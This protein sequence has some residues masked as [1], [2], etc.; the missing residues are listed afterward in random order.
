VQLHAQTR[1]IFVNVFITFL[2]VFCLGDKSLSQEAPANFQ[3]FIRLEK[4]KYLVGESIRFWSGVKVTDSQSI[5]IAAQRSCSLS[6]TNPDGSTVAQSRDWPRGGNP[7]RSWYG[8]DGF[9]E[10]GVVP[11]PYTLVLECMGIKSKPVQ[12]VVE[13]N[14]VTN[15]VV[16]EFH[17]VGSGSIKI[18]TKVPV[19]LTVQNNS[20]YGIQF[21]ERNLPWEAVSISVRRKEPASRSDFFYP[22][23]KPKKA[24]GIPDT[25]TWDVAPT[26]PSIIL[27]SGERFEQRFALEEAYTFDQAGEYEIEF[28]TILSV[29]IGENN[30]AFS[31]TCPI[32]LPVVAKG[33]FTVSNT[34]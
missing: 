14:E 25:Y 16:A 30:G 17:F 10:L 11:G 27:Q 28:A 20:P 26:I 9:G 24:F 29:L 21:P 6:I 22:L 32:R 13:K 5:P 31:D 15:Q 18:G 4:T 2:I 12:M 34:K 8:G 3:P 33:T 23:Q 1:A 7:S 19:V